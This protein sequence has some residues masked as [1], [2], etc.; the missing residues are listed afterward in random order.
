MR[1]GGSSPRIHVVVKNRWR[2]V[3][4]AVF[5]SR[6]AEPWTGRV[7]PSARSHAV[8]VQPHFIAITISTAAGPSRTR[9]IRM[10][11]RAGTRWVSGG[12]VFRKTDGG[13]GETITA[14]GRVLS[15]HPS[16]QLG[17]TLF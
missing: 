10:G 15:S 13:G 7:E 9:R 16:S 12:E 14:R 6:W 11:L 1:P 2:D 17:F 3:M 4:S 5:H 8:E